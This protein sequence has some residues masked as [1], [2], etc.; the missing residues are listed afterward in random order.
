MTEGWAI[1]ITGLPASGKTWITRALIQRLRERGASAQVLESDV[2]RKVLTPEPTYAPKERE[3]FYTS[4]VYIG[5]LLL[6]N[7]VNVIFDA[8]ANRRRWRDRAREEASRFVEVYVETPPEI[9]RKRDPKGIYRL[10]DRGQASYV[11]G[12]QEAYEAPL[13]PEVTLD[14]TRSPEEG[15]DKIMEVLERHGLL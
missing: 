4:M 2:L 3:T 6:K 1:W 11:P 7:G 12:L 5:S 15:A 10:A 8:V 14:G 13:H 9:C